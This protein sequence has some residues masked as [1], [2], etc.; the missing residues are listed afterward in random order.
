LVSRILFLLTLVAG[1]SQASGVGQ[2]H[3]GKTSKTKY[4]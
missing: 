1:V 2:R 4:P 3:F